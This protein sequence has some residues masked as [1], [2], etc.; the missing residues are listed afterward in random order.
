MRRIV[1]VERLSHPHQDDVEARLAHLQ[2]IGEHA[3]LPDDLARGQVAD[4]THPAGEAERARHRAADLRRDAEG[5]RR[6][7]GDEDRLDVLAVGEAKEK[8][9]GAVHRRLPLSQ[10]GRGQRELVREGGSKIARQVG[11]RR[12]V[13]DAAAVDPAEDLARVKRLV[14]APVERRLEHSAFQIGKVGSWRS[15]GHSIS[16]VSQRLP[17]FRW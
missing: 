16:F 2:G 10:R 9:L 4:Q 12:D 15:G 11:H 5:H 7:V 3:H 8:L 13:G 14:P 1:I 6:R 17:D